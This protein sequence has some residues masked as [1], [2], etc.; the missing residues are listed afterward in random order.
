MESARKRETQ[1]PL[2]IIDQALVPDKMV[3]NT[4]TTVATLT[5]SIASIPATTVCSLSYNAESTIEQILAQLI[6]SSEKQRVQN[7][8]FYQ[9]VTNNQ[10]ATLN[11]DIVRND[12]SFIMVKQE[13]TN[14][15]VPSQS[16][17]V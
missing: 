13:V 1:Q 9:A 4:S 5:P 15:D 17:Y 2:C 10:V 16:K 6:I 3:P 14:V 11:V 12:T 8:N 7:N